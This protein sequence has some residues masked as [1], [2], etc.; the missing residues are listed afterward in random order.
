MTKFPKSNV[1]SIGRCIYVKFKRTITQRKFNSVEALCIILHTIHVIC[2]F[3]YIEKIKHG[4]LTLFDVAGR[5]MMRNNLR[6]K[7]GY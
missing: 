1:I 7:A 2:T 3:S 6:T 4:N 5:K